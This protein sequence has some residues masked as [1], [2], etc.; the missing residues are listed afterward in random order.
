VT[1]LLYVGM[2][3]RGDAHWGGEQVY[4]GFLFLLVLARCGEAFSV[5]NWCGAGGCERA[6]C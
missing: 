3:R 2:L 1:W 6:A 5:D 4:C